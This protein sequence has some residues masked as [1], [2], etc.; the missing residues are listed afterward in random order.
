M[1]LTEL[2]LAEWDKS[3]ITVARMG[4]FEILQLNLAKVTGIDVKGR[5]NLVAVDKGENIKWVAELPEGNYSY[6]YFNSFSY[7]GGKLR[8]WYGGS[9]F[10]EI[11]V[12]TGKIVKENK[13]N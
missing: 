2:N 4:D 3:F 10:I 11:D 7:K 12:Q 8:G 1:K 6:G 9:I 13:V 5:Q